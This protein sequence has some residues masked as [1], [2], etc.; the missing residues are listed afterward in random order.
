MFNLKIKNF[1]V[2]GHVRQYKIKKKLLYVIFI[3]I[4]VLPAK[5]SIFCIIY[6][7]LN[8]L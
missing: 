3:Q 5:L 2:R 6:C 7:F 1:F 8:F 4:Y